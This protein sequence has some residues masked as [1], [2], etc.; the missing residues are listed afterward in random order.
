MRSL[1]VTNPAGSK[2][3]KVKA[4]TY[5]SIGTPYCRLIE[6]AVPKASIR[7][8]MV[9]PSLAIVMKSSPGRPSG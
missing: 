4:S 6:T 2:R 1:P 5:S 3:V 7:P 9:L 8:P